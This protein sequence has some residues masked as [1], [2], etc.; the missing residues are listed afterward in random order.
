M[1]NT[2]T[3]VAIVKWHQQTAASTINKLMN[4]SFFGIIKLNGKIGHCSSGDTFVMFVVVRLIRTPQTMRPVTARW[5]VF[6]L[7]S[8]QAYQF[9]QNVCQHHRRIHL[10]KWEWYDISRCGGRWWSVVN[11]QLPLTRSQTKTML[12][13]SYIVLCCAKWAPLVGP[14][15]HRDQVNEHRKN[16][17]AKKI[18]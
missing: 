3:D 13:R 15:E 5:K 4:K 10:D 1:H 8:T 18:K 14:S 11:G 9:W 6:W 16:K 2:E 12:C 7:H 17:K